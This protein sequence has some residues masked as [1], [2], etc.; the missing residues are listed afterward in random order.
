M[1]SAIRIKIAKARQWALYTMLFA[2]L[3]AACEGEKQRPVIHDIG[4]P[5][6]V[7]PGETV[8]V[9]ALASDPDGDDTEL[10]Y[11]WVAAPGTGSFNPQSSSL[12]SSTYTAPEEPGSYEYTLKVTD[13]TNESKEGS[14]TVKV[15]LVSGATPATKPS[16]IVVETPGL[17][18]SSINRPPII[19]L[20]DAPAQVSL[21]GSSRIVAVADDPDGDDLGYTWTVVDGGG[22]FDPTKPGRTSTIYNAPSQ[23]GEKLLQLEV[24]DGRGGAD[25]RP[26]R[27]V[28]LEAPAPKPTNTPL[29]PPTVTPSSTFLPTPETFLLTITEPV[30][31][32]RI[33]LA[34]VVKGNVSTAVPIDSSLWVV[35][36]DDD[37]EHFAQTAFR[38]LPDGSWDARIRLGCAWQGQTPSI[39]IMQVQGIQPLEKLLREQATVGATRNVFQLGISLEPLVKRQ[40]IVTESDESCARVRAIDDFM[41]NWVNIDPDTGG[42]TRLVIQKVDDTTVSYHGYGKCVPTDC[43]WGVINVPLTPEELVGTYEFG[44][45]N[46]RITVKLFDDRLL[47]ET[48]DDYTKAD[49]RPD[50]TTTYT[51]EMR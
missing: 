45:K 20:I 17:T 51:L 10:T 29:K 15:G 9:V 14:F 43:D 34:T 13:A 21:G 26:F 38:P 39:L 32:T 4:A 3:L 22:E 7:N 30:K 8:K 35:M 1:G 46:T 37:G 25:T 28:V 33:Q 23:P 47:A 5:G 48:F 31:G 6:Q 12:P 44:F 18:P 49:G 36:E 11:T 41:G 2:L 27:I 19:Q 50:R 24:S 40:V 16:S 42:M